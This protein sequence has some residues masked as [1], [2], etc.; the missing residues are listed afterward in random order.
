MIGDRL[1]TLS[2]AGVL[3]SALD[4]LAGGPFVAFPDKPPVY[5]GCGG[6]PPG[7]GP[8]PETLVACPVT[9]GQAG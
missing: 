8:G 5:G 3:S 6:V 7:P 2:A 4:T 1:F 9:A